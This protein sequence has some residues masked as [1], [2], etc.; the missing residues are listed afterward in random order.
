MLVSFRVDNNLNFI[1]N[2][3]NKYIRIFAEHGVVLGAMDNVLEIETPYTESDLS[4]LQTTQQGDILYIF[5]KNHPIKTLTR[6]SQTDWRLEDFD[7]KNGPWESVNTTETSLKVS[8]TQGN[9]TIIADNNLFKETDIGRLI[10]ITNIN[11]SCRAWQASTNVTE[12]EIVFSDNKYYVAQSEGKT[13]NNKPV[14]TEGIKSDGE[15]SFKF[16]HA[17]Y[18]IAKITSF[19]TEKEVTA[20]VISEFPQ[21]L[22]SNSSAYW[23]LGLIHAGSEYPCCGTFFRG[24]FVFAINNKGYSRICLSCSDDFN[25]FA[26]KDYGEVLATNAI[27]VPVTNGLY[28]DV[29]WVLGANVLFIGTKTSEAY[30]D[31]A[32][33]AE[34]LSSDNVKIQFISQIGSKPIQPIKIGSHIIFVTAHGNSIRDIQYSFANDAYDPIDLS[35]YGKHLLTS[36]IKSMVYQESP[37]K[38]IWFAVNDGRLI[39]LTFSSEQNVLGAHQHY[40]NGYVE[41]LAVI[42]NSD[43]ET[44]DLWLLVNRDGKV[45]VEWMDYGYPVDYSNDIQNLEQKEK[46][47]T[48]YMK[49]NAFYVDSGLS[50]TYTNEIEVSI[51]AET[52]NIYNRA[53]TVFNNSGKTNTITFNSNYKTINVISYLGDMS[54]YN[55]EK[56]EVMLRWNMQSNDSNTF[57]LKT[58]NNMNGWTYSVAKDNVIFTNGIIENNTIQFENS[59]TENA[60]ISLYMRNEEMTDRIVTGLDHLEG[61]EVAI[62]ADGAELERQTVENGS[63]TIPRKYTKITVGLPIESIVIPQNIYLQGNNSSGIG[64]VQRIDH[65]TL[66]LWRSMGGKIGS[67]SDNL[68]PLYFRKTDDVM[69]NSSPLYT[70]NKTEQLNLSTTTIKEKGATIMIQNDSVYPMNIL[71]IAPH[72]STSGNGL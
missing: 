59:V 11:D 10:R 5:H 62:M 45:C 31:V 43:N 28:N 16:L 32:S 24:R 42:P 56:N 39:G 52:S 48:E 66:M 15:I 71:A 14:H 49:Q 19:T 54:G 33:S 51:T 20:N 17:G 4:D 22:I 53:V 70:G 23:E 9:I 30:I 21:E 46:D 29:C 63:I 47:E 44:D 37:D 65:V 58:S 69:G 26:D 55:S 8:A 34:A 25:N 18:G 60:L 36:G 72:F 27:T 57:T 68:R 7:I 61:K 38:I 40:L 1:L 67:N 64:D 50:G 6:Y 13:G 3:G 41:S 2:F 35:L 12:G